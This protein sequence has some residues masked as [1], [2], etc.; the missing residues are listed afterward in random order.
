MACFNDDVQGTGCVTLAGIMGALH[1][2]KDKLKDLRIVMFGAGSAGTGIADQIRGA[3]AVESGKSEE[4]AAKQIW[5]VYRIMVKPIYLIEF[6]C[7]DKIGVILES[8][9]DKLT[10]AQTYYAHPDSEY[11]GSGQELIDVIKV[12]KPHVLIGTS[13]KPGA[14]TEE[15]V[16]EMAKGVERPIIFPLSNPTRLHEAKPADLIKWTDGKALI[17]TGSPFDPVEYNGKK[18]EIAECNNSVVFPGIGLGAI[19]CR[20]RLVTPEILVAAT[21]A[22]ASVSPVQSNEQGPLLPDVED[23]RAVSVEIAAA[24]IKAAIKGKLAQEE[25]IPENDDILKDW[26]REQMWDAE[27]RILKKVKYEEASALGK[28]EAGTARTR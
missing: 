19:L 5:Y 6:R 26:I 25:D 7:V 28:G 17:A 11:K 3:I 20:T 21:K 24:V 23:V 1:V 16:R 13:T 18:Y 22:V 4:E 27:Y 15:V 10:E 12:V 8:K 14:F 2:T 9:K